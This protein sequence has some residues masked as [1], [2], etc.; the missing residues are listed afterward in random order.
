MTRLT[1]D[2]AQEAFRERS[3][4]AAAGAY[5]K[6]ALDYEA[7]DMIG[8]DTFLN[9]VSEIADWLADWGA[10][11]AKQEAGKTL[12]RSRDSNP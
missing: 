9:A 8:D 11:I 5:L 10:A 7:D 12:T 4:Q 6:T 3:T 1:F 2:A